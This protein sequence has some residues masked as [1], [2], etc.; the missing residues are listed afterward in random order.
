MSGEETRLAKLETYR[1]SMAKD[2]EDIKTDIKE[3]K[4]ET[5]KGFADVNQKIDELSLQI[6]KWAGAI[7]VIVVA[8]QFLLGKFV[9]KL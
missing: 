8:A 9:E 3:F 5:T 1:E 7:T 2:I 4:K 6:A